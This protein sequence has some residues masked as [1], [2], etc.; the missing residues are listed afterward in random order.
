LTSG[1]HRTGQRK[2][3][4][5]L[6]VGGAEKKDVAGTGALAK[7]RDSAMEK[8]AREAGNCSKKDLRAWGSD[9]PGVAPVLKRR[10][11]GDREN[12]ARKASGGEG[13]D[14]KGPGEKLFGKKTGKHP[15][16]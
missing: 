16:T 11:D 14:E 4:S 3:K 8:K 1:D 2:T 13:G 12:R 9:C 15:R 10:T 5:T 6:G 7:K